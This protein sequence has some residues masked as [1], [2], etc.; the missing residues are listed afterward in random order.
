MGGEGA[1]RT[2]A[3]YGRPTG[4]ASV[5]RTGPFAVGQ[6]IGKRYTIIRLLGAGG[7]GAVYQ[8]WDNEL[9]M[10]V[11]I[12]AILPEAAPN[13]TAAAELERRFKRELVLARNITHRNIVR[14]HDIGE[15]DGTKYLTMSFIQG[16]DLGSLLHREGRLPV[17]RALRFARDIVAGLAAAH[18]K[19][20]VHR[21]LK[22]SNIMIDQDDRAIVTDFGIARSLDAETMATQGGVVG[23]LDYMSPEQAIAKPV[24]HRTDQYA[25]GLILVD[26]LVGLR[27]R[28]T[29]GSVVTRLMARLKEP[30]PSPRAF[31]PDIP[32]PLDE[33][34]TTCLQPEPEA[35]FATTHDLAA[36][37]D[38]L[39][40]D[41]RRRLEAL[42]VRGGRL[43]T[44]VLWSALTLALVVVAS[45]G[46]WAYRQ[47]ARQLAAKSLAPKSVLI[48]DFRNRTGEP[49][50]DGV[51]E[52]TLG[53]ALE[54]ASFVT[55]YPR[56]EARR[57]AEQLKPGGRLDEEVARLMA[58]R[59]G[60]NF[61]VRGEVASKS[62][63]YLL[64]AGLLDPVSGTPVWARDVGA[65]SKTEVLGAVT[66]LADGMRRALGDTTS[67][68]ARIAE[69]ET[70]T[71]SSLEAAHAYATG[72]GA[73]YDGNANEAI[74]HYE[75]AIRLDPDLGRAY[76]GIAVAR[77]ALGQ[78]DEA[79]KYFKLAMARHDRMT[80]RERFRT[81]SAYYLFTRNV[82]KAIEELSAL[83]KAYPADSAGLANL[84][85][86]RFYQ[87]DMRGALEDGRRAVAMYPRNVIR[88]SNV[89]LYAMYAGD[90][91]AAVREAGEVL[92]LNTAF[93]DA[94]LVMALSHLVQG[95]VAEASA[96]W[97]TLGDLSEEGASLAATG[98]ADLALFQGRL[99]DAAALLQ[100]GIAADRGSG[101]SGAAATKLAI[102]AETELA[103]NQTA[104]AI[105]A[106]EAALAASRSPSVSFLAGRVLG[107]AGRQSRAVA[108]AQEL[109]QRLERDPQAYGKLLRGELLLA[110]GQSREALALFKEA[111][112][113]ADTWLGR[114][115]MGRAYL[116]LGAFTEA[117]SEFEVCLKRRG[118]ATAIF[119]DDVPSLRVLPP[120]HY[121]AGRA[122]EGLGSRGAAGGYQAFLAVKGHAENDPLA[123]DARRRLDALSKPR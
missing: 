116:E 121:Y 99:G 15:V 109:E 85:L 74:A 92:K 95:R 110:R 26:M 8:A 112:Q 63:G 38:H 58:Q 7:M 60:I 78:S 2:G 29:E 28:P 48:A 53:L 104:D 12:K 57:L 37:L 66:M 1:T 80:E 108:L 44:R 50:M 77:H 46:W 61:V 97:K 51:I 96:S 5:G 89:A 102:L 45:L 115:D 25:L 120:V 93:P 64:S 67:E 62:K 75:H 54:G 36:A 107:H 81:R 103:R 84:A 23:T 4:P 21:D 83:V 13:A 40:P 42:P 17:E 33:L 14:I 106:A 69:A 65:D 3:A 41:G 79:E 76:A 20:V 11:A 119:L 111:R 122:S 71:S 100:K 19:G 94:Y 43:R 56:R 105:Q 39:G 90:F 52:E 114:F 72:Q 68:A 6:E 98:L 82:D 123:I 18:E 86:A 9:S 22:P 113:L 117:Q 10:P 27:P 47:V 118:E 88:R 73:L 24:D 32:E 91:A 30:P 55:V 49:V 101:S 31:D 34:V 87:R 59:D 70:F 16:I 35:R